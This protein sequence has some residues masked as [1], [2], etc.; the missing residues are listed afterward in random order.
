MQETIVEFEH[1]QISELHSRFKDQGKMTI[2][3]VKSEEDI[4]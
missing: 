1:N 4:Q 2:E 3:I